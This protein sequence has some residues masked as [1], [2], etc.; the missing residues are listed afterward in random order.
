MNLTKIVVFFAGIC[1]AV[2]AG[3]VESK[4]S[5]IADEIRAAELESQTPSVEAKKRHEAYT[6][7]AKLLSLSNDIEGAAEA[8]K[9]AAYAIPEKRDDAALVEAAFCYFSMGNWEEARAIIQLLLLTARD[10]MDVLKRAAYI[11]AQLDALDRGSMAALEAIAR[12]P[13]YLSFRPAIYYTLWRVGG[14]VESRTKL[15]AEFPQ[16]PEAYSV[17]N[18]GGGIVSLLPSAYW[19]LYSGR[20]SVLSGSAPPAVASAQS[21]VA[22]AQSIV[23]SEQP[24]AARLL[25]AGLYR[26]LE[27]ALLQADRLKVAGFTANVTPRNVNGAECWAVFVPVQ[28]DA[29]I[30][31]AISGLKKL[32]FEAFPAR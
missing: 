28:A 3:A 27:N 4:A 17:M 12:N 6:Q 1:A 11:N 13:E 5:F 19:L 15:L 32:G 29:D 2:N 25:Q 9:N 14:K 21:A 23:A 31:M 10:N 7:L 20:E 18:E 24:L 30:N 8:W 26:E 22:S 16:S